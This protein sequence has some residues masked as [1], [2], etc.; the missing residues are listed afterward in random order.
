MRRIRRAEWLNEET[1]MK[2]ARHALRGLALAVVTVAV[3]AASGCTIDGHA[4]TMSRAARSWEQSVGSSQRGLT[5]MDLDAATRG[6]RTGSVKHPIYSA[7]KSF[8]E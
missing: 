4:F 8:E 1:A 6:D 3:T 5:M 2:H 7:A